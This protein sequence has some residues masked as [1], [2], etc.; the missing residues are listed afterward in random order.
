MLV[1]LIVLI[2]AVLYSGGIVLAYNYW[3][4]Y[5]HSIGW[6]ATRYF[7]PGKC[8]EAC[9]FLGFLMALVWPIGPFLWLTCKSI[10]YVLKGIVKI[11]FFPS[12]PLIG[13]Y[14][15]MGKWGK[16]LSKTGL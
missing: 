10:P 11:L 13:F 15:L 9:N 2:C 12:Y 1:I 16:Q 7:A 6:H 14:R 3:W 8:N 4:R 5:F